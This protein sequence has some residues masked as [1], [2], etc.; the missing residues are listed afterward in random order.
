M[1]KSEECRIGAR[2][3]FLYPMRTL[4]PAELRSWIVLWIVLFDSGCSCLTPQTQGSSESAVAEWLGK[5]TTTDA[6]LRQVWL[7]EAVTACEKLEIAIRTVSVANDREKAER[8]KEA[9]S[10]LCA[11]KLQV[12]L[13]PSTVELIESFGSRVRIAC[14]ASNPTECEVVLRSSYVAGVQPLKYSI[15]EPGSTAENWRTRVI[16]LSGY[17]ANPASA[18]DYEVL[19]AGQSRVVGFVEIPTRGLTPGAEYLVRVKYEPEV[20]TDT[21]LSTVT[22]DVRKLADHSMDVRAKPSVPVTIRIP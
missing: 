16:T 18:T 10:R 17:P 19:E 2:F 9:L 4:M 8:A 11:R 6:V 20:S 3:D 15:T 21:R 5:L 13:E 12:R 14:I 1:L 7:D 22:S